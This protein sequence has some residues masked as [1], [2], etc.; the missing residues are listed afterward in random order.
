LEALS[1]K[2]AGEERIGKNDVPA[3]EL[4]GFS[5]FQRRIQGLKIDAEQQDRDMFLGLSI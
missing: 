3:N 1:T 4:A 2:E 5:A